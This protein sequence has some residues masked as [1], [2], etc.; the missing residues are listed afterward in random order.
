MKPR[1]K[2]NCLSR[3]SLKQSI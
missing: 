2:M 3:A 1:L